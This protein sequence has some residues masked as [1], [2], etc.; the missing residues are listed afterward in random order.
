MKAA[1]ADHT[2]RRANGEQSQEVKSV[3]EEISNRVGSGLHIVS[4][5]IKPAYCFQHRLLLTNPASSQC[6]DRH[7]TDL[8]L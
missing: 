7:P 1:A 4:K 2:G 5:T 8:R 6:V 3:D